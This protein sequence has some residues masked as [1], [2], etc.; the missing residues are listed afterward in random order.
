M[1][2]RVRSA[3]PVLVRKWAAGCWVWM[4][5]ACRGR[6]EHRDHQTALARASRHAERCPAAETWRRGQAA[7]RDVE[8]LEA[9]LAATDAARMR[10]E[11]KAEYATL[12]AEQWRDK[13]TRH[14]AKHAD[15]EGVS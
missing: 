9:A 4:C 11:A 10:A 8:S 15:R 6:V 5:R 2:A 14:M 12:A 7:R 1:S 13:Y 3:R